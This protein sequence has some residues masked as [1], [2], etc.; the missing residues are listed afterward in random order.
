M[1]P[2]SVS[3]SRQRGHRGSSGSSAI[4]AE[5][6]NDVLVLAGVAGG[7]RGVSADSA[8]TVTERAG[9]AAAGVVAV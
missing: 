1:P 4:F 5:T 7:A 3:V 9:V 6:T 2:A 8:E